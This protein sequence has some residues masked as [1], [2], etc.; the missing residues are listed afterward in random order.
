MPE[1]RFWCFMLNNP[2]ESDEQ[3]VTDLL[4]NRAWTVYGIFGKEISPSGTSYFQGFLI[5]DRFRRRS[6]FLHKVPRVAFFVRYA[7]STNEDARDYCKKEGDFE[8]FGIFPVFQQG[9]CNDLAQFFDW[10]DEF[11]ANYGRAPCDCEI[12][13][14]HPGH[15]LRYQCAADL[16][17][18]RAPAPQ[19]QL[20]EPN[21]W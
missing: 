8:E 18:L 6:F 21:E 15:W 5:L 1:S 17:C 12:A 19:L 16:F 4:D 10:G 7:N 11:I 3:E 20:G 13:L 9:K 2:T 14:A